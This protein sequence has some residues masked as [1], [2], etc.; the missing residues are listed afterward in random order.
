LTEQ[1]ENNN[2]EDMLE[3]LRELNYVNIREDNSM[4]NSH[5]FLNPGLTTG[6]NTRPN[7]NQRVIQ[8]PGEEHQR[9]SN[10]VVDALNDLYSYDDEDELYEEEKK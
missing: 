2:R 1:E 9:S 4:E 7:R 3:E 10:H 5:T 8:I 6:L